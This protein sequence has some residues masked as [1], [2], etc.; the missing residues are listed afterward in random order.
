[1]PIANRAGHGPCLLSLSLMRTLTVPIHSGRLSAVARLAAAE[2]GSSVAVVQW[3]RNPP[4][5]LGFTPATG[6][7]A[8]A[9]GEATAVAALAAVLPPPHTT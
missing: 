1:M 4:R 6:T 7:T 5:D 9:T 3:V 8:C 2:E